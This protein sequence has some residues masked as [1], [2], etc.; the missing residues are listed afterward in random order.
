VEG[1]REEGATAF[2][3]KPFT[4]TELLTA[5]QSVLEEARAGI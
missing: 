5:V 1:A 2:V 4:A 3:E